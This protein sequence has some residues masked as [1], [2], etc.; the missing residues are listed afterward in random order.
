M[1]FE[2]KE[3]RIHCLKHPNLSY[4]A[5]FNG[6]SAL[7]DTNKPEPFQHWVVERMQT[8]ESIDACVVDR[9]EERQEIFIEAG[10][11]QFI[12]SNRP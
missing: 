10:S 8:I 9:G 5:S 7:K 6:Y 4:F 3:G 11:T 12:Y 1:N 2:A